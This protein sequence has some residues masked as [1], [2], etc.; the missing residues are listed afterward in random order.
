M[1]SSP[2][3]F[4]FGSPFDSGRSSRRPSSRT[5][6]RAATVVV[7]CVS[8]AALAACAEEPTAPTGSGPDKPAELTA[9]VI[10]AH[11]WNQ[12]SFTQGVET[13]PNGDLLVGTGKNGASRIYKT[14]L[15]GQERESHS[16]AEEHFGE[17]IT[18]DGNHVWQLTW[19]TNTA[20][21][22]NL[23]GLGE[24]RQVH[25]DGEGWGI[26]AQGGPGQRGGGPTHRLVMSDGSGSLIFRDPETFAETGRQETTAGGEPTTMLNELEC[27]DDGTVWANVWQTDQVYRIDPDAGQVTGVADLS[28]LLPASSKRG[29]DVLNGIAAVPGSGAGSGEATRLYLTG[30]LWDE[31]YEVEISE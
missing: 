14:T 12:S 16:L 7:A 13:L 19:Q 25:Y 6:A 15:N 4:L 3:S 31:M 27:A 9:T 8:V 17:G 20:F 24:V 5:R 26:C 2:I 23:D 30:K 21:L 28:G 29:A 18:I 1:T 11:P 10:Q 22:R